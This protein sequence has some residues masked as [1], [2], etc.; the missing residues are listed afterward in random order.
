MLAQD[1][2]SNLGYYP[3]S[4]FPAGSLL[5]GSSDLFLHLHK[6]SFGNKTVVIVA[7][8]QYMLYATESYT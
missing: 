5:A 6:V 1:S 7:H 8:H 2:T 3:Q 4:H